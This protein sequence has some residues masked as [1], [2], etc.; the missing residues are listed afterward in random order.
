[1]VDTWSM[2]VC[3]DPVSELDTMVNGITIEGN[4]AT[5][6]EIDVV[7][8]MAAG[9]TP[10]LTQEQQ[11]LILVGPATVYRGFLRWCPN[12]RSAAASRKFNLLHRVYAWCAM[13]KATQT[14]AALE[15]RE[16]PQHPRDQRCGL[17]D[18]DSPGSLVLPGFL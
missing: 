8:T 9:D 17:D 11:C 3:G 6:D 5:V 2:L 7:L 13:L 12:A 10:E 15:V 1:M 4:D 18:A 14:R 16:V